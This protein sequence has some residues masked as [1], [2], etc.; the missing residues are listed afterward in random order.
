[1]KRI[2]ITEEQEKK[3]MENIKINDE[4]IFNE[5]VS[6]LS[7]V[8]PLK[9]EKKLFYKRKEELKKI[10][11]NIFSPSFD[12][13]DINNIKNEISRLSSEIIKME[14]N[15]KNILEKLCYDKINEMLTVPNDIVKV[16]CDL[17]TYVND[18]NTIIHINPINDEPEYEDYNELEKS[19]DEIEKRKLLKLLINGA[20]N[21]LGKHILKIS[22]KDIDVINKSLY[23]LYKKLLCLNEYYLTFEN[24]E[25]TDKTP[26][27]AGGVVVKLGSDE[28]LTHINSVA[29]SFPVLVY[30]TLKGIFELF[31]SHGLPSDK[32]VTKFIIDQADS[33]QNEQYS[34]V[35]GSILWNEIMSIL[36]NNNFDTELL[37]FFITYLSEIPALQIKDLLKEVIF[38]TKKGKYEIENIISTVVNDIEYNDFEDRLSQKRN[39]KSII[40][41]SEYM[42]QDELLDNNFFS[43]D[44][45]IDGNTI[46]PPSMIKSIPNE[47]GINLCNVDG[48]NIEKQ[49]DGQIKNL[50]IKFIPEKQKK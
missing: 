6:V 45:V 23:P 37:P 35:M 15:S 16:S 50:T 24:V 26:N 20:S 1:M 11:M 3:L 46:I 31:I 42:T 8:L 28:K 30:E 7:C 4:Y 27:Q 22:K 41:D 14:L 32:N 18:K 9:Q 2:F 38:K 19:N 36:Y 43:M 33:L 5:D 13:N 40:N 48:F 21:I 12:L 44:E 25:I 29:N 47:M 17:V 10:C 49:K 34:M 39:N